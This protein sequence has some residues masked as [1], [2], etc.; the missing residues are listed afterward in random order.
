VSSADHADKHPSDSERTTASQ[1]RCCLNTSEFN[2]FSVFVK[3]NAEMDSPAIAVQLSL[4]VGQKQCEVEIKQSV[5]GMQSVPE[6]SIPPSVRKQ[7]TQEIEA[8]SLVIKHQ[9]MSRR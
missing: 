6:R 3:V 9:F 5:R 1:K 2:Q 4:L 7:L 8:V